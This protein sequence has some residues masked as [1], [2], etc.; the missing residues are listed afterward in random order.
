MTR[1]F[2][3]ITTH[4]DGR[5]TLSKELLKA[6]AKRREVSPTEFELNP[7]AHRQGRCQPLSRNE[8]SGLAVRQG[9]GP[10]P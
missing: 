8:P 1:K 9:K 7:A 5:R 3:P 2:T 4:P 6:A 10:V